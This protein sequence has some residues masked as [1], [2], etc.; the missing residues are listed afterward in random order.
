MLLDLQHLP[1]S[2]LRAVAKN[3]LGREVDSRVRCIRLLRSMGILAISEDGSEY[4]VGEYHSAVA[5]YP[6]HYYSSPRSTPSAPSSTPYSISSTSHFNPENRRTDA[7]FDVLSAID[8]HVTNNIQFQ[9]ST[10]I[11]QELF[12]ESKNRLN[13]IHDETERMKSDIGAFIDS[14]TVEPYGDQ[15]V[16][17]PVTNKL[18]TSHDLKIRPDSVKF[19]TTFFKCLRSDAF[20]FLSLECRVT[21]CSNVD[22]IEIDLPYEVLASFAPFNCLCKL[23]GDF[24]GMGR[25]YAKSGHTLYVESYLLQNI[26]TPVFINVHGH[27]LTSFTEP[28]RNTPITWVTPMRVEYPGKTMLSTDMLTLKHVPAESD[29]GFHEGVAYFNRVD[30]RVDLAMSVTFRQ[31]SDTVVPRLSCVIDFPLTKDSLT[32]QHNVG[33]G[34]TYLP[35]Y[36]TH[37][38]KPP[39]VRLQQT[40][41]SMRFTI[42]AYVG[43]KPFHECTVFVNVTYFVKPLQ[44]IHKFIKPVLT[45]DSTHDHSSIVLSNVDM[46]D[47]HLF[48]TQ[49]DALLDLYNLRINAVNELRNEYTEYKFTDLTLSA[50]ST[51]TH[52]NLELNNIVLYNQLDQDGRTYLYPRRKPFH[53]RVQMLNMVDEFEGYDQPNGGYELLPDFTQ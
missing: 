21:E 47:T 39:D 30:E 17:I 9:D 16:R 29:I 43:Y 41:Q 37:V 44:N 40:D 22:V 45:G 33:Y 19:D 36:R 27:Y 46:Y 26:T 48:D 38:V 12:V 32:H 52:N 6:R 20:V 2:V 53:V 11:R 51:L 35:E 34:S 42:D 49:K 13:D 10:N 14:L 5:E 1:T 18:G 50:S 8:L 28:H 31:R 23:V 4:G 25:A 7:A 3:A 24:S 15:L